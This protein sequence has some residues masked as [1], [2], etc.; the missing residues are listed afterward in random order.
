MASESEL[1]AALAEIFHP[2]S[3]LPELLIGI[4]DDGAIIDRPHGPLAIAADMAVEDVHFRREWSSLWEIGAK[5]TAA[6]IADIYAMGG[7]PQYLLVTAALPQGFSVEEISQLA[8]GIRDEA[9]LAGAIVIG[10]DLSSA[11]KLVISITAVGEVDHIVA[12]SGAQVGDS[13]ILSGITGLSAA[14]LEL[15]RSGRSDPKLF[16]EWHKNPILDSALAEPFTLCATAMCDVSDGLLSELN[17]LAQSSGVAMAIDRPLIAAAPGFSELQELATQLG[18]DI[19]EWVL[20][21]GEDHRLLATTSGAIP[22][23]AIVIGHV[24]AGAGVWVDGSVVEARG[25]R[26][27]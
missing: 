1:I 23:G 12:R 2:K 6:N 11:E 25:Y 14:G 22:N 7:D 3:D 24:R 18:S 8:Q 9:A 19:W 13:I 15:L 26:H 4:G 16:I 20:S 5:V 10:G 27:F 17:H 21:G